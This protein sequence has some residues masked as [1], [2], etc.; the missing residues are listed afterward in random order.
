MSMVRSTL[1]WE[2]I[3]GNILQTVKCLRN[4][5]CYAESWVRGNSE[6]TQSL[7]TREREHCWNSMSPGEAVS[8][9][10]QGRVRELRR[11]Q[12]NLETDICHLSLESCR[13]ISPTKMISSPRDHTQLFQPANRAGTLAQSP[14]SAS[15]WCH[16]VY[17]PRGNQAPVGLMNCRPQTAKWQCFVTYPGALIFALILWFRSNSLSLPLNHRPRHHISAGW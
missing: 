2:R 6:W 9:G 4:V 17:S 3:S 13:I 8:P 16:L 14:G 15:P 11:G 1:T 7:K 10:R 5:R 12:R